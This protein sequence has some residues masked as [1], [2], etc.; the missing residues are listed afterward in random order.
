MATGDDDLIG[1]A[2]HRFLEVLSRLRLDQLHVVEVDPAK[3]IFGGHA[4]HTEM[5]TGIVIRSDWPSTSMVTCGTSRW[6]RK[7][8]MK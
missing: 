2:E 5:A 8:A 6:A 4:G 7:V 1:P 3:Q